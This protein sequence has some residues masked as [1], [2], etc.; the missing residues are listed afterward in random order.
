MNR[1]SLRGAVC[2][3]GLAVLVGCGS[4]DETPSGPGGGPGTTVVEQI[5]TKQESL[6]KTYTSLAARIGESAAA[7]S[8]AKLF[9]ADKEAVKSAVV[10]TQGIAV[11]FNNGIHGGLFLKFFDSTQVPP[12]PAPRVLNAPGAMQKVAGATANV[13]SNK[14]TIFLNPH[15]AQRTALANAIVGTAL[16]G[17]PK[18]G[19]LPFETYLGTAANLDRFA[20]LKDYGVVHLYT[21]GWAW[22]RR[23]SL[24]EVYMVTGESDNT[25]LAGKYYQDL[26]DGSVALMYTP[27]GATVCV[28]P[29]FF[30]KYNSGGDGSALYYGGFCF[31]GLGG[32][33]ETLL[34]DKV[35]GTV[36]TFNWSVETRW[37]A[38]WAQ[39][40]YKRLTDTTV[41]TPET[42]L[43]WWSNSPVPKEYYSAQ[44]QRSVAIG[45][46]GDWS[47]SLW[48]RVRSTSLVPTSGPVGTSLTIRGSGFGTAP[49]RGVVKL[50]TAVLTP[51]SWSD[52]LITTDIPSGATTGNVTVAVDGAV[53]NPLLFTVTAAPPTLLIELQKTKRIVVSVSARIS[54][55]NQNTLP[56]DVM[57]IA[58]DQYISLPIVWNGPSF[59]AGS[60]II[61]GKD[62]T[63]AQ[64]T[65]GVTPDGLT[66]IGVSAYFRSYYASSSR[67]VEKRIVL[68]N[69]PYLVGGSGVTYS[70]AG[71][72]A[73]S[74]VSKIEWK[75]Y[76]RNI[77]SDDI[78]NIEWSTL[79]SDLGISA[80]FSTGL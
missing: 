71:A 4:S 44:E 7:D 79:V 16:T 38:A 14:K 68:S 30:T 47:L 48:R 70:V 13:P 58:H 35:A 9:L 49:A 1:F 76:T 73:S 75:E 60:A 69:V 6:F 64:F 65:G 34:K 19:F 11:L 66:L 27:E 28:S 37:N 36:V 17:F 33:K 18:A 40:V 72:V 32:W 21:H 42:M 31:S 10:G 41:N 51:K 53:S 56:V 61:S 15:Y 59:A 54:F 80:R 46:D 52:S 67:L 39:D 62:T 25:S 63:I 29:K 78:K 23:D 26:L 20:S 8:V 12:P 50:G 2:A 24:V 57:T 22:P 5:S 55:T 45:C 43:S 74:Y 77:L 3:L